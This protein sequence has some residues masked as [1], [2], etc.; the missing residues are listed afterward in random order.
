MTKFLQN[1]LEFSLVLLIASSSRL[2]AQAS[3]SEAQGDASSQIANVVLGEG[4]GSP[5]SSVVVPIYVQ[6]PDGTEIGQL[7]LQV[8]FVSVNLKFDK[9]EPGITAEM[10]DFRIHAESTAEK[11][12]KDVETTMLTVTVTA[13]DTGNP[14]KG[15]PAGLLAYILLNISEK[16]RPATIGLRAKLEATE[17]GTHKALVNLTVADSTVEVVA[18]GSEPAVSCFFFTH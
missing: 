1:V 12:E 17:Q 15:I 18:P 9:V 14:P 7:R 16:A 5:G 11:N 4:S 13:P 2:M 3:P 6:P 10:G 8:T